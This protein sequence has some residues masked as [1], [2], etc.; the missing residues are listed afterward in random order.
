MVVFGGDVQRFPTTSPFISSTTPRLRYAAPR[1]A[2]VD[3]T[4]IGHGVDGA[5]RLKFLARPVAATKLE[6]SAG[7][8]RSAVSF[9][10]SA[11]SFLQA[12]SA[13]F[14]AK[15]KEVTE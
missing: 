5:P 10:R 1:A 14:F 4:L 11:S 8:A 12:L 6:D 13:N 7:R 9:Q 2:Q 3:I 15:R